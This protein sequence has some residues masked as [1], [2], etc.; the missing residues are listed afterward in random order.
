MPDDGVEH[1]KLISLR[2]LLIDHFNLEELKVLCFDLHSDYEGLA[3]DTK[4]TKIHN[5]IMYLK[6]RGM[7]QQ[8]LE[9][10]QDER[11]HVDWPE[12]EPEPAPTK[13]DQA[14]TSD[15]YT[16]EKTKLE[17]LRVPAGPFL[18]GEN[19]EPSFLPEFWIA[20][21]PV[22]NAHYARFLADT[23]HKQDWQLREGKE[24]RPVTWVTWYDATAY[25]V[26][27]RMQ[28]PKERQWEKAARGTDGRIYPWGDEWQPY[29]NI[30]EGNIFDTVNIDG[31]TPV[32]YYSP[33]GD[34]PYGCVDMS[35]NVYEWT[36]SWYD[37]NK[38]SRVLRGCPWFGPRDLA[39]VTNRSDLRPDTP[40]AGI[41]F[42]T[43]VR[44][45]P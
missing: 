38:K 44:V 3:G 26:W 19:K 27:A 43:V 18:Y 34:S 12:F 32:G 8:L 15:S 7:L 40:Y 33:F 23:G 24:D 21:T 31:T 25:A 41:G 20:K 45:R 29:C 14:T 30:Q 13:T 1:Q 35:G 17:M 10:V 6:R 2:R 37:D 42:R 39:R 28:L 16:D 4:T 36:T 5:F 22:T 9:K 11:P